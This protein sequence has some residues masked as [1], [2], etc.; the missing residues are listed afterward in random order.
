VPLPFPLAS[1][2]DPFPQEG[3]GLGV[4]IATGNDNQIGKIAAQTAAPPRRTTLQVS[5]VAVCPR[6]GTACAVVKSYRAT[7]ATER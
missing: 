2:S 5:A 7:G 4:V 1:P 3:S 6:R